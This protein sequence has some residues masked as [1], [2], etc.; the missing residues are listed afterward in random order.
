MLVRALEGTDLVVVYG[1]SDDLMEFCGAI[2]DEVGCYD[3]FEVSLDGNGIVRN[4][5]EDD[6]C[7]YFA[8]KVKSAP[9]KIKAIWGGEGV[10][11]A[12]ETNIPHSKFRV[13]EDDV[14][15]CIG[16]VFRLESVK[17]MADASSEAQMISG[18]GVRV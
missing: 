8:E 11:W 3:G 9:A 5:C 4:R 6:E 13:V 12:Y 15:Y 7:P 16:I 1:A 14:I 2:R 18:A 17:V 10:S